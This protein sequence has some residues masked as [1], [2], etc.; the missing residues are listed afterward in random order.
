MDFKSLR[1]V[2]D[3]VEHCVFNFEK[4][5]FLEMFDMYL[6][7][8][9][10][11]NQYSQPNI[12]YL[13]QNSLNTCRKFPGTTFSRNQKIQRQQSHRIWV[14]KSIKTNSNQLKPIKI[15]LNQ[16]KSIKIN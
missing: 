8:F 3:S 1:V 9:D 10:I 6:M 11:N 14:G 4:M 15:N 16:G 2:C 12:D 7:I 5:T 13:C